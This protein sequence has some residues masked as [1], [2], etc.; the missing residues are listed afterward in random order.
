[1]TAGFFFAVVK[2]APSR[3]Y[4]GKEKPGCQRCSNT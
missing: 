4:D 2:A 1:L 3:L